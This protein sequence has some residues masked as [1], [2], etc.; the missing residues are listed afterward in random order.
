MLLLNYR[1]FGIRH[2]FEDLFCRVFFKLFGGI[3]YLGYTKSLASESPVAIAGF[4]VRKTSPE[5]LLKLV[6]TEKSDLT[7]E[8]VEYTKN[9]NIKCLAVFSDSGQVASYGFYTSD[10]APFDCGTQLALFNGMGYYFKVFTLVEFRGK[11]LLKLL[12]AGINQELRGLGCHTSLGFVH[13]HNLSSRRGYVKAG[14]KI[15][16]LMLSYQKDGVLHKVSYL[17]PIYTQKPSLKY[18]IRYC[19]Q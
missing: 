4:S 17:W 12:M 14:F 19:N 11:G 6:G 18:E 13:G 9:N 15:T 7:A 10:K 3:F 16:K 2:A 8:F 5:E 1:N